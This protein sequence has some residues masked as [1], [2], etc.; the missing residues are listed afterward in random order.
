MSKNTVGKISNAFSTGGGGVN[1]EQ[2][3]QA[4]FLLSLLVDGFCPAM[5]ESTKRVC[6]QAKHLGYDVDDLVVFTY[7][8]DNEGKMLCQMKHSILISEKDDVFQEVI[9]AAWNDFNRKDFD[10]EN[11]KI[12]LVT[13]QIA[14]KSQKAF[15]FLHAQAVSSIDEKQFMDRVNF[16]NFSNNDNVRILNIIKFCITK[17]NNEEP[18]SLQLWQFCK[19]FILL[20]FDLDCVESV[21][22]A[23]SA[24]L[25]K[26]NSTID[27]ILVWARLVEYASVCNQNAAS[28]DKK[29]ID[30]SIWS[31]FSNQKNIQI[32]PCPIAEIDFFMPILALVG[33]WNEEND[34]D[35]QIVERI[36]GMKY[37]EFESRARNM[38][39]QNSEYL[40]LENGNWKV[41]HKEELLEQCKSIIFDDYIERLFNAAEIVFS[42]RSKRGLCKTPYYVDTTG[43]YDNS[44]MLRKSLSISM[45]W[46][47]KTLPE[48]S[49]CN[50]SKVECFIYGFVRKILEDGE[51]I[52]W[53]S[54]RE[55]LSYIAELAPDLFLK[56]IEWCTIYKQQ[57]MLSL[58]PKSND[59]IMQNNY[60]TEVLWAIEALAWSPDYLVSSITTLGLL[61]T[62]SYEKTNWANTPINS[63]VSILLPWHPQTLADGEKRKNAL[64][65]LKND[66]PAVFW[67]VLL[68]LL[69]NQTRTTSE[70][71][72]PQYLS[73]EIPEEIKVSTAELYEQYAFNLDMAVKAAAD[74]MDRLTA[75]TKYIEYMKEET[76][77]DYLNCIEKNQKLVDE[78]EISIL[79]IKLRERISRLNPEKGT[80]LHKNLERIQ[81]LIHVIEPKNIC[82][83]YQELYLGKR[84]LFDKGDYSTTWEML[85]HKKTSAIKEI[86]DQFGVEEVVTFGHAVN[87]VCDVA[88]KL[89]SFLNTKEI[90]EIIDKYCSGRV[91]TEFFDSC[92]SSFA[93]SHGAAKMM[94]TSLRNKNVEVILEALSKF[95]FSMDLYKVIKQLLPEEMVYWKVATVPYVYDEEEEEEL[96]V[97]AKKF[98]ECARYIDA[99]NIAGRSDFEN[100]FTA[101]SIYELLK[102]AGTEK[103][104][105]VEKLDDYAVHRL[106][107]WLQQQKDIALEMKSDIEFIYLPMLDEYSEVK[108]LALNTRL[109]NDSDYFCNMIEL[110]Y[111]K[112][113]DEKHSLKLNEGLKE[114]LFAILFQYK[115]VPGIDLDG[116]FEENVFKDWM[117]HVKSWSLKNERY[118]VTM[119]TVGSGFSYAELNEERLPQKIIMEE[120]N[121]AENEELRRG[122]S[123]G[124]VNQR[125]A[126]F[127]DPEG[128]PEFDLATDYENRACLAEKRGYSRYADVLRQIAENYRREAE[129]NILRAK[130]E[131]EE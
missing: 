26:C 29:N 76:L 69:P 33:S 4:M 22:R 63:I 84:Y 21:N 115:V 114:R 39:C 90:S 118:E 110:F 126:H 80:V 125:G 72:K 8:N 30:S 49:K 54:L 10:K 2:Q 20:L 94:E 45:G 100:I 79:W 97:V 19:C 106:I 74:R 127:I 61:E 85:E 103:S 51:W 71:P 98:T 105:G 17:T 111:K 50:Q 31:L 121:K 96:K 89:G 38:L 47:K 117:E 58:F 122:Y 73:L 66:S 24:S 108:P 68:K 34:Y 104:I 78:K 14:Y 64:I 37:S 102:F 131:E 1:F 67:K 15:R 99:V 46:I 128:K 124:I 57:E 116:E 56:K 11:D 109:S 86:Y 9:S 3:V 16:A 82:M 7:R 113:S 87:N 43:E 36:S 70:N 129:H 53:V 119:Q 91:A 101:Q 32:P 75:L 27:A 25:I 12:A 60:I 93:Y 35:R 88:S 41:I 59:S 23:L 83:K 13:A 40:E 5:N 92:I 81:M 123:L 62:L 95:V 18:T 42:Q 48:L 120:L 130:R 52:T 55:C 44:K 112:R 107:G 6:F 65:C 77:I 28:V